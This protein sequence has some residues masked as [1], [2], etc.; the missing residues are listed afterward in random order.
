MSEWETPGEGKGAKQVSL[1][2]LGDCIYLIQY[3][4]LLWSY[5][6]L[7]SGGYNYRSVGWRLESWRD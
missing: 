3:I 1:P 4:E 2:P 7:Y 6:M 5:I